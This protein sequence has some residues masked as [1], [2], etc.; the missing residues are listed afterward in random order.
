MSSSHRIVVS[1]PGLRFSAAHMATMGGRL[2]PLHGHTYRVTVEIEAPLTGDSWVWDFGDVRV[3]VKEVIAP[4]DHRFLLQV[5]SDALTLE[6]RSGSWLISHGSSSYEIPETDVIALP[7]DNSTAERLA[8]WIASE[9]RV[10]LASRGLIEAVIR[11][12]VS[13]GPDQAGWY[14]VST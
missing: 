2:E 7:I 5:E 4:L 12:G 11:V 9:L 10:S 6:H 1:G 3:A 14:T 8:E 13:E